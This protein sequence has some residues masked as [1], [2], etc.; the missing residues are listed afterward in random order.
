YVVR[1]GGNV[2]RGLLSGRGGG[3]IWGPRYPGIEE[4]VASNRSLVEICAEQW[5]A[6]VEATLDALDDLPADRHVTIRYEDL[7]S[8]T[9]ALGE[10]A[11]FCGLEGIDAILS[12]HLSRVDSRTDSK[13][14]KALEPIEQERMLKVIGP[15]LDRLGYTERKAA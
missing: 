3:R 10:V 4:D 14:S 13:W 8:G 12:A 7:V 1:Y 2:V 9:E 5:R 15:L 6:S 11:R